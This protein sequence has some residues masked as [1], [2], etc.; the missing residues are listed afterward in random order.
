MFKIKTQN[1]I[2]RLGLDI[3]DKKLY[4]ISDSEASPDAIIVRSANM[5]GIEL[6][7]ELKAIARA[8]AGYNNIPVDK[9]AESGIVVFNSPGANANAV[10][11]LTVAALLLA[12]RNIYGAIEWAKTLRTDI[13]HEVESGKSKYAGPELSGKTLG[14]IGVGN[15]GSLTANAGIALGMNVVGYDPYMTIESA[16]SL[17]R[18]VKISKELDAI[19][20]KSDYIALHTL[21]T[22]E[23]KNMINAETI[24]KMK[25]GVRIIN[26]SRADIVDDDAMA[27]ALTDNKV[28]KYVTDFPNAKVLA[29]KNTV[30]IPHLASS[31]P[32]SEDKCAVMAVNQII[33]Y[34][35]NGNI[36][37]SVNYPELV[38]DR[39]G[40]VR[41]C[42]MHKNVKGM[43]AKISSDLS[44]LG[45]NIENLSTRSRGDFA[46]TICEISGNVPEGF[47]GKI[48]G[49][50]NMIK[51]NVIKAITKPP[52]A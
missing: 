29:M 49:A 46:Y 5:H 32:E 51:V 7:P 24:A 26:M 19:I 42:L 12:S 20:E 27:A 15:T 3:F 50:P 34:L 13:E 30:A 48:S 8:G 38:M 35:E 40:N 21:V 52:R 22:P 45:A 41:I 36:K 10:K 14:I 1:K 18:S 2:T 44:E 9:C 16:L 23:T 39:S 28:A 11:E 33:D 4:K 17:S 37:N 47:I 31:T 25:K 43:I 6:N